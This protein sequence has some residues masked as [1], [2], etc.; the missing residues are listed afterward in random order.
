M[1]SARLAFATMILL[2]TAA[3][4]HATVEFRNSRLLTNAFAS[5]IVFGSGFSD[6]RF[7]DAAFD[8][9]AP[10]RSLM[11]AADSRPGDP[12]DFARVGTEA[13]LEQ[14]SPA[15]VEV[16]MSSTQ[17]VGLRRGTSAMASGFAVAVYEFEIDRPYAWSFSHAAG[18]IGAEASFSASLS[19]SPELAFEFDAYETTIPSASGVIGAGYYWL[20]FLSQS[21][22]ML[23]GVDGQRPA[24][25]SSGFDALFRFHLNAVDAI[26]EPSNWALMII[27]FSLA[28]GAIRRARPARVRFAA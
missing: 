22:A 24:I 13:K 8:N 5:T 23:P 15:A 17:Q 14:D 11:V 1:G 16:R 20:S 25:P 3:P 18:F 26:P 9:F 28:G 27:G 21:T 7:E 12:T 6:S 19:S 2:G 10:S 4:A